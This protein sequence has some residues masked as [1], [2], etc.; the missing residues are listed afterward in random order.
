MSSAEEEVRTEAYWY[1]M[2]IF[3]KPFSF[4]GFK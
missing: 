2:M 3:K 4:I 1:E